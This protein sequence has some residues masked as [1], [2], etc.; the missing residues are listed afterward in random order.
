MANEMTQSG[1]KISKAALGQFEKAKSYPKASTLRAIAQ[2]FGVRTNEL[3]AGDFSLQFLGFRSLASLSKSNRERIQSVM[4]WHAEKR[5]T[6]RDLSGLERKKWSTGRHCIEVLEQADEIALQL[7]MDWDLG[8]DAIGGLV[9]VIERNGG[10]VLELEEDPKFSG[11]SAMSNAGTPY[12]AIQRR[13]KD[14]A[15]QR[16]DLAHE[17]AH[18]VFDTNSPV[19]EEDFAHRF[20]S[21]FLLPRTVL[22][23]ELG[24][25]RKNLNLEELKMLKSKYGASVQAWVRRARDCGIISQGTYKNLSFRISSAGMRKDEG[26]PYVTPEAVNRN[27]RLAARCVTERILTAE[28]AAEIAGISPL[29]LEVSPMKPRITTQS[30][31]RSLSREDRRKLARSGAELSAKSY[32]ES[33]NDVVPDLM[34]LHEH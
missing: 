25:K 21:A 20:A 19:N 6:L 8:I 27:F 10:E 7:R 18:I 29:D 12:L 4:A 9:D 26:A 13:E 34:D 23:S 30:T 11:L 5:E 15:R 14:G 17:L 16:M 33:P 24:A 28:E 31:I 2:V 3:L 32:Q 1:H 22:E